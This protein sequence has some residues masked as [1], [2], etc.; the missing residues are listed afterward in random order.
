[1]ASIGQTFFSPYNEASYLT[2]VDLYFYSVDPNVGC[3]IE[4]LNTVSGQPGNTVIGRTTIAGGAADTTGNTPTTVTFKDPVL[5]QAGVMYFLSVQPIANNPNY[6]LWTAVV[7]KP[8]VLSGQTVTTLS[9]QGQLFLASDTNQYSPI[10]NEFLKATFYFAAF[11]NFGTVVLT[12]KNYEFVEVENQVG[13]FIP[14]EPVVLQSGYYNTAV[15]TVT[16]NT[17]AY[18]SNTTITQ[19]NTT[20]YI[21]SVSN[22]VLYVTNVNGTFQNA[23]AVVNNANLTVT[24]TTQ[25]NV[26]TTVSNNVA[27]TLPYAGGIT[28]GAA[29]AITFND[30]NSTNYV[31][32]GNVTSINSNTIEFNIPSSNNW[33]LANN[34][35]LQTLV[36]NLTAIYQ[37]T[38]DTTLFLSGSTADS[39]NNFSTLLNNNVYGVM[40]GASA[41][42]LQLTDITYQ[43][44]N[45]QITSV[46]PQFTG[47][48]AN[49]TFTYVDGTTHSQTFALNKDL[50]L[51][52]KSGI[53]ASRTHEIL[54]YNGAKSFT[55]NLNLISTTIR[56]TP[57]LFNSQQTIS[58]VTNEILTPNNISGVLLYCNNSNLEFK[59]AD[60]ITQGNSVG[61][62]I[63]SNTSSVYVSGVQGSFTT[64]NITLASN[65]NVTSTVTQTLNINE[66][67][68]VVIGGSRYITKRVTLSANQTAEDLQLF[69]SAYRPT[70]T[71]F[72]CYA[73]IINNA[74]DV[75]YYD[76][77]W[78]RLVETSDTVGTYSA[79]A[80]TNDT[81]ELTYQLPT[82]NVATSCT[83]TS[84]NNV[85]TLT[86][87]P[88]SL[89]PAGEYCWVSSGNNFT[90]TQITSSN[91][92][93]VTVSPAPNF[94]TSNGSINLINGLTSLNGGFKYSA[95]NGVVR[96]VSNTGA[97]YDTYVTFAIKIVP[98]SINSALIPLV[99]SMRAIALQV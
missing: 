54:N 28:N 27:I 18:G 99:D 94:T 50:T 45:L 13:N 73:K 55:L 25:T 66:E 5:L 67:S 2:E 79:T 65:T 22:N 85:V 78:T 38:Q 11:N 57:Y 83:T 37:Y 1:M 74:D 19:G 48:T 26:P 31:Y 52:N 32:V 16:S 56:N 10:N 20:G 35:Q 92:T 84:G 47:I 34:V 88:N 68:G 87:T 8:D 42:G 97:V 3:V 82:D 15:L 4:I 81:L 93:A 36:P 75:K 98:V 64:G 40:S 95:N 76:A 60:V 96:Y 49:G 90:V 9:G 14:G 33:T 86:Q 70:G 23:N 30:N 59:Q 12:N 29:Y 7:G 80:N 91:N 61:E 24:V 46:T 53:I 17:A 6:K 39:N 62:V 41:Q 72:Y 51:V 89:Y 77:P 58:A 44:D 71:D 21:T 63:S 69:L 43:T